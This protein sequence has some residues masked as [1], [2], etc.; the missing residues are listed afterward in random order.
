MKHNLLNNYFQKGLQ[1]LDDPKIQNIRIF[2][3]NKIF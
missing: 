3:I 2:Y 1:L